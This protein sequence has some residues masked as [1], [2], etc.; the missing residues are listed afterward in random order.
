MF[1][2]D[3]TVEIL[4]TSPRS[5]C[6]PPLFD[7]RLFWTGTRQ[8]RRKRA[9]SAGMACLARHA[10]SQ[11]MSIHPY[12][13]A[14]HTTIITMQSILSSVLPLAQDPF[15]PT[16]RRGSEFEG[17][18]FRL[19]T[20]P[21]TQAQPQQLLSPH[22]ASAFSVSA[23]STP[24]P[25]PI[26]PKVDLLSN[27]VRSRLAPPPADGSSIATA[28]AQ[29]PA[30][31]LI[32]VI[33][34]LQTAPLDKRICLYLRWIRHGDESDENTIR[35]E[36]Q[37]SPGQAGDSINSKGKSK[38]KAKP[39]NGEADPDSSWFQ[40]DRSEFSSVPDRAESFELIHFLPQWRLKLGAGTGP[41][42]IQPFILE[43]PCPQNFGK[44]LGMMRVDKSGNVLIDL[45]IPKPNGPSTSHAG[46]IRLHL[47]T[48]SFD[49][50][51]KGYPF[52]P[53]GSKGPE[54]LLQHLG[55]ILP[56]HWYVHTS[57][58]P[59][60]YLLEH[61]SKPYLEDE[62]AISAG[63]RRI[64][65]SGTGSV[66]IEK[67]WGHSFPTGWIWCQA[68]SPIESAAK[69]STNH[70]D[71]QS[72]QFMM[73]G[74]SILYLTAFLIGIRV[75]NHIAWD[76]K[77]PFALGPGFAVHDGSHARVHYGP[78]MK[79]RR[80]FVNK[81]VHIQVWDGLRWARIEIMADPDTF[82]TKIPGPMPG[83]WT[84]GYCHHS[85][86]S[87]I[88]I[89]LFERSLWSIPYTAIS[90]VL[91]PWRSWKN[92]KTILRWPPSTSAEP[93]SEPDTIDCAWCETFGWNKLGTYT[94]DDRVALEFGGDFASS[95]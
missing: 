77:P 81:T 92:I 19:Q 60:N 43:L 64:I 68:N 10:T 40:Q 79:I 65:S 24:S 56:L 85:Y 84:P 33:C 67:N 62:S 59:T 53:I 42:R 74:G 20:P 25:S 95:V 58:T 50:W 80:D 9:K 1:R 78:G 47:S 4:L 73:A 72:I 13:R 89:T 51:T 93:S 35:L 37:T 5:P 27:G 91:H 38:A 46:G 48:N 44:N 54:G 45:T 82:A 26:K 94:L 86:R 29:Q 17:F 55:L 41:K 14:P 49:P 76:F 32:L 28:A 71:N 23:Q 2:P 63:L 57:Q 61:V 21:T 88:T 3:G 75:G 66:H 90:S 7:S 34:E 52:L 36:R 70:D 30:G 31:D 15:P 87:Q 6:L 11:A 22:S 12:G 8:S 83:G 69:Q 18:F 39:V 16:H